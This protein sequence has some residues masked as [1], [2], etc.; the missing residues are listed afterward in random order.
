MADSA[1]AYE[2]LYAI[3]EVYI[4]GISSGFINQLTPVEVILG[5][6]LLTPGLQTFV[7]CE[8]LTSSRPTRN[9]DEL[10]GKT[11][12]MKIQRKV[13]AEFG[14]NDTFKL[15]QT[16]YR[17]ADRKMTTPNTEE[18]LIQACDHTLLE[19]AASL[20]S[21]SWKCTPPHSVVSDVLRSCAGAKLLDIESCGPARDYVAENIHPFQVV[22]QQCN[23]ALAGGTDPSFIHYM[24]F[25]GG[26]AGE[27]GIHHFR[28][29][30]ELTAQSV[31][32]EFYY[33]E[34]PERYG[35][36]HNILFHSFPC[37]FDL[38]SD[39]LNGVNAAGK[40]I[41][42]ATLWNPITNTF[43][44]F[45][46]QVLGCGIGE[47][48]IRAG[49]TNSGS[50]QYQQGCPDFSYL[51]LPKRQARMALL[52]QDKIALRLTVPW[53]PELHAGKVIR[54]WFKNTHEDDKIVWNYGTGDYLISSLT[55]KIKR[56]GV[57]ST[58]M[59]CVSTTVGRGVQ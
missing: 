2:Y 3:P 7:R 52:E 23:V 38:L 46:S 13:L 12:N 43:S 42:S 41:N 20:V 31:T 34:V 30:K 49:Q 47:A 18:F 24:T 11:L 32:T 36:P 33:A 44:L 4:Q 9:F 51:Y 5:E 40:D 59:D 10:K 53:N 16:I 48:N 45:G 58:T 22:A 54:A 29:L 14:I 26:V 57:A 27:E 21:K 50:E 8:A 1:S 19:D 37:D 55:H 25:G 39:I 15:A 6:S 35:N 56:G 28:S 17:V